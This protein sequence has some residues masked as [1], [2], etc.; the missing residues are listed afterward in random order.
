MGKFSRF[1]L[2]R[3]GLIW[4]FCFFLGK[5]FHRARLCLLIFK[6]MLF[7]GTIYNRGVE[8]LWE[9]ASR[10]KLITHLFPNF[11][12]DPPTAV[13]RS[14]SAIVTPRSRTNTLTCLWKICSSWE[15]DGIPSAS[16]ACYCI[17]GCRWFKELDC[18][19]LG[20]CLA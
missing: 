12:V 18:G 2:I 14:Q 17:L 7:W 6:E 19:S 5:T 11:G 4:K 20:H 3:P 16:R 9:K 13:A 8:F 15:R 10:S 1:Y